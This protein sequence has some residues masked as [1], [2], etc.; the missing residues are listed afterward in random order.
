MGGGIQQGQCHQD[1]ASEIC[2]RAKGVKGEAHDD[3]EVANGMQTEFLNGDNNG[4][5]NYCTGCCGG[6]D[7]LYMG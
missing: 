7:V 6:G 1:N 3:A 5:F 4:I 2:Q